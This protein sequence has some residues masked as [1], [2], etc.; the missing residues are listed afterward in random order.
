VKKGAKE[1]E[2]VE[3]AYTELFEPFESGKDLTLKLNKRVV[4]SKVYMQAT[5]KGAVTKV[6]E[7]SISVLITCG[8]AL[9]TGKKHDET[10]VI[11]N[12]VGG[13]YNEMTMIFNGIA[14]KFA[15]T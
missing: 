12:V 5:T 4:D 11:P 2:W 3:D 7:M 14:K 6:K 9:D 10:A 1:G 13:L 8:F 15:S